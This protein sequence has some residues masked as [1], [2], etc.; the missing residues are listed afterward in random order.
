MIDVGVKGSGPVFEGKGP[1]IVKGAI[2]EKLDVAGQ[3][4]AGEVK[5]LTPVGV[6][7]G[8]RGS[9]ATTGVKKS[10]GGGYENRVVTPLAYGVVVE[11]G[12]AYPGRMPPIGPIELWVRRKGA[13]VGIPQKNTRRMAYLIARKIARRGFQKQQGYRMF[14]KGLANK[15]AEVDKLIGP[16]CVA[17]ITSKLNGD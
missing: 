15:K 5:T 7:G 2:E 17:E 10:A 6:S 11:R 9:V 1:G 16:D 13:R 3:L 14:E 8:L 4:V 12:R